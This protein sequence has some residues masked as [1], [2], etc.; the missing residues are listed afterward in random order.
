[1]IHS[2]E[3]SQ[4]ELRN[5]A[6]MTMKVLNYGAT[7]TEI[8]VPDRNRKF[9]NIVLGFDSLESYL[10]ESNPYFGSVIGRFSNR[11]KNGKFRIHDV[12]YFTTVNNNGNTLHGGHEGFNRKIWKANQ[13][14][15]S[16]LHLKY[17]SPDGEEGF[18]G[19]LKTEITMTLG[20]DNSVKI[21]YYATTDKPTPV[22]LTNHTY[23][24]LSYGS[25]SAILDHEL[26][27]AADYLTPTDN[28]HIPTGELATVVNTPFD[29][30][31][32]KR[33]GKDIDRLQG[34][35]DHNFVLKKELN[36]LS[37]AA[38]L[39]DPVSGRKLEL[40]TTEPG[41]QFYT[42]NFLDGTLTG[43]DGVNYQKHAGLCLE[44]QLFPDSPNQPSFPNSI[45]NPG[46]VYHQTSIY[47]FSIQ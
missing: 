8:L 36:Q 15:D 38:I 4:Y 26:M 23:F 10:Q 45:L 46:Q 35:Y 12:E 14:S 31:T 19:N 6:G 2:Q 20:L 3:I 34:G 1:M 24:N 43:K 29:F 17:S 32:S 7:I 13:I 28:M 37:L 5:S 18:P 47:K 27:I 21:E 44:P 22:S 42:G 33:I 41:L 9:T 11:I 25:S 30:N 40:F 39:Y 16:I